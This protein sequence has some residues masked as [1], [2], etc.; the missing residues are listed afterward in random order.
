MDRVL[1]GGAVDLDGEGADAGASED[2]RAHDEVICQGCVDAPHFGS[3]LA[4]GND[5]GLYVVVQ[6]LVT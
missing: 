2:Y 5:V 3:D 1:E 6:L 4:N